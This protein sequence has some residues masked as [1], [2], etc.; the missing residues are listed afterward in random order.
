MFALLQQL[1]ESWLHVDQYCT[2][3]P[4]QFLG[5]ASSLRTITLDTEQQDVAVKQERV[6]QAAHDIIALCRAAG[7]DQALSAAVVGLES[8]R[9]ILRT[10]TRR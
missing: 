7:T 4:T 10:M 3:G 6:T 5:S 1:R 9:E 8:L 2:P